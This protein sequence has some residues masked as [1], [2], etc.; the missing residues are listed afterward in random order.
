MPH[1]PPPAVLTEERLLQLDKCNRCGPFFRFNSG[2]VFTGASGLAE[3]RFLMDRMFENN[4]HKNCKVFNPGKIREGN[5][6]PKGAFAFTLTKSPKDPLT[7]GDMLT[8][9]RKVMTQKSCPVARYAW[10]YED[11]GRD[12]NG[13]AIH[14][15]IHGMYET[16]TLGRIEA[17]HWKRA[18]SVWNENK[19]MG[20]GF[21]GGYH[22]PVKSDEAYESYIKKDGG[23]SECKI[24]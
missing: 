7:V 11:K 1:L 16:H 5:G 4:H 15:H 2:R 12:E 20:A 10:Y 6:A 3:E 19:G 23:M 14:P 8:A 17:K 9:V 24:E 13:D 21:Q 22:R 18:W